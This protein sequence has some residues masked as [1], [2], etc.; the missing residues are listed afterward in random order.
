MYRFEICWVLDGQT[1][2]SRMV[3]DEKVPKIK[4]GWGRT[5]RK[6]LNDLLK[7]ITE[8]V[9][10]N[11]NTKNQPCKNSWTVN[12]YMGS[13]GTETREEIKARIWQWLSESKGNIYTEGTKR[14][15]A[16][17]FGRE[18][19]MEIELKTRQEESE[20]TKNNYQDKHSTENMKQSK[21]HGTKRIND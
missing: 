14:V 21:Q 5:L 19:G 17:V 7:T 10:T 4:F 16:A 6:N 1:L 13:D 2:L 18:T 15:T 20:E 11:W 12:M 9:Q 8:K 3:E